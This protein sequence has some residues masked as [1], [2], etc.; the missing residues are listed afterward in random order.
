[1]RQPAPIRGE[2]ME[3][4]IIQ[5]IVANT[6]DDPDAPF[7]SDVRESQHI[8]VDQP[9]A[10]RH[11]SDPNRYLINRD[12]PIGGHAIQM[13]D[14]EAHSY[15]DDMTRTYIGAA[16]VLLEHKDF[17]KP[18]SR[19]KFLQIS[20][21]LKELVLGMMEDRQVRLSNLTTLVYNQAVR[22]D[23]SSGAQVPTI[24][25]DLTA[26][27]GAEGLLISKAL[28]DKLDILL[29]D[30]KRQNHNANLLLGS[31]LDVD[32]NKYRSITD[33]LL[34]RRPILQSP[35]EQEGDNLSDGNEDEA[36]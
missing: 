4:L 11:I 18:V 22:V 10:I 34:A 15:D 30:L 17:E 31:L 36:M 3:T 27:P 1:M 26:R 12:N 6:P 13:S 28:E 16:L 5:T 7:P 24:E 35:A 25:V 29:P 19:K 33:A 23:E 9:D 2:S 21:M 32:D 14:I 8:T 20:Q